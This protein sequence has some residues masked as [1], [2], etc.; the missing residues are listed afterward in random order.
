MFRS[1]IPV[2][3]SGEGLLLLLLLRLFVQQPTSIGAFF[4]RAVASAP[5]FP[6]EHVLWLESIKRDDVCDGLG[7]VFICDCNNRRSKNSG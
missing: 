2:C 1:Y 5:L 6:R 7:D 4:A 3:C